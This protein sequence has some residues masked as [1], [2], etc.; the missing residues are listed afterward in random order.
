MIIGAIFMAVAWLVGSVLS[1]LPHVG[2]PDWLASMSDRFTTLLSGHGAMTVLQFV[3]GGLLVV[4][5]ASVAAVIG[6]SFMIR[7]ARLAISH[8]TGGGGA[9]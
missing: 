4:V 7:I 9:V 2:T 1:L 6:V 5:A 3:P 8:M